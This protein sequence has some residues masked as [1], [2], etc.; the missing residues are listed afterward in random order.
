ME[1]S[2]KISELIHLHKEI[3]EMMAKYDEVFNKTV[4][5]H[6]VREEVSA[7][8]FIFTNTMILLSHSST[9]TFFYWAINILKEAVVR[10]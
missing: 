10:Q 6:K 5:F 9:R 2:E 4:K 1:K 7:V 8:L 3:K